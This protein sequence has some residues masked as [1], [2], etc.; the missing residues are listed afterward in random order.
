MHYSLL[1]ISRTVKPV[2][3][4]VLNAIREESIERNQATGLTGLLLW[5]REH[6]CQILQGQKS[7]VQQTM[8]RIAADKRHIEPRV[9]LRTDLA[10]ALFP[11]W[12]MA[13]SHIIDDVRSNQIALAYQDRL[14]D[15]SVVDGIVEL[16][17][18]FQLSNQSNTPAVVARS[19]YDQRLA[20]LAITDIVDQTVEQ[21]LHMSCSIFK[22]CAL[23]LVLNAPD[24]E[25]RYVKACA[26]TDPAAINSILNRLQI[27]YSNDR[28]DNTDDK[29]DRQLTRVKL[30]GVL[31]S[32][33]TKKYAHGLSI[34]PTAAVWSDTFGANPEHQGIQYEPIGSLWI[35]SDNDQNEILPSTNTVEF[36]RLATC[37]ENL[38]EQKFQKHSSELEKQKSRR[39]QL[40]LAA[41]NRRQEMVMN[42]ASSAIIALD[43][44]CRVLI[45]NDAAR[46]IFGVLEKPVPFHWPSSITFADPLSLE[47]L[48]KAGCPIHLAASKLT[49]TTSKP[50]IDSNNIVALKL[51]ESEPL[52]YLRVASSTIDESNSAINGVVVFDDMTELHHNRERI[53]RSDRLEALGHLTGG[54]AHDFN[55]LLSTLQSSV[56][57]ATE[58]TNLEARQ[59]FLNVALDS[60]QRGA[61][62]TDKLVTFAVA[63]PVCAQV[64]Q[65][66]EI[67]RSVADLVMASIEQ[68]VKFVVEE[69]PETLAVYCDGG[70]LENALLNI[71]FN[72]RD[73]IIESGTGDQVSIAVRSNISSPSY[74]KNTYSSGDSERAN[75]EKIR[76]IVTDNGPGMSAEVIRRATD[77][78]FSTRT[79]GSG[80]GL[81]LSMVY[82]F[83]EQSG[84]ELFI[85]NLSDS[86]PGNTGVRVTLVLE[87]AQL[88]PLPQL[89]TNANP[90]TTL[91]SYAKVLLVEDETSLAEML[92]RSLNRFGLDTQI[93]HSTET[94]LRKLQANKNIDLLLTDIVIAGSELDGY[95]LAAEAVRLQPDLKVVYLSGYPQQSGKNPLKTFG[96]L[97]KKPV[98]IKK[99][100]GIIS[101]ELGQNVAHQTNDELVGS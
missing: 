11:D 19:H 78:F 72:S 8:Q 27:N 20:T 82:R 41:S 25:V 56:E 5:T 45:I 34:Y 42:V 66:T 54:I 10:E 80:S 7:D 65:L 61:D 55:N 96:P 21:I 77:P 30:S 28:V 47:P 48:E 100:V 12:S 29:P 31:S 17:Q 23:A 62:L 4:E 67:M 59:S 26:G 24:S 40:S 16:M 69:P 57:L 33:V 15:L 99:L 70:Q 39:Q 52:R 6:Y 50:S 58:E 3:T 88:T 18:Q 53:R 13:T 85:E 44:D 86:Q 95:S 84:G 101:Q 64:H 94:A 90:E 68:D 22:N 98:S 76:I 97:I 51:D 87:R 9:L 46:H 83:V 93:A 71:L 14:A 32:S 49:K 38:L 79:S 81:G 75:N 63:R 35:L 60:V 43:R 2:T 36:F 91:Q 73:A 74:F 1:Y 92:Q 37:I 89:P